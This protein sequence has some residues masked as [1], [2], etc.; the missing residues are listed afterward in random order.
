MI[1][2]RDF[3]QIG[4]VINSCGQSPP[5]VTPPTKEPPPPPPS[6]LWIRTNP[7]QGYFNSGAAAERFETVINSCVEGPELGF[8]IAGKR[9]REG[10]EDARKNNPIVIAVP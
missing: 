10:E 7:R 6:S 9:E 2:R 3:A 4:R 5:T 1:T 8:P